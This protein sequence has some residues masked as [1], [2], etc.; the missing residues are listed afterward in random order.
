MNISPLTKSALYLSAG[1]FIFGFIDNLTLLI[2]DQVSVGQF[3]FSRSLC[4]IFIVVVFALFSGAKIF[5][6]NWKAVFARAFFNVVAML[7]YF[8]VIPMMPIA[9]AGAGLFT[10]PI[11]VLLFSFIFF[12]ESISKVQVIAF[13]LGLL[14]VFLIFGRN[15]EGLTFYHIFPILAGVSYAI[16]VILTNRYCSKETPLT[17]LLCFLVAIGIVGF[18]I[19]IWFTVYPVDEK[20]LLE[21]PFLF[22]GW[23]EM[24]A[25]YWKMIVFVGLSGA[26]AIYLMILAYQIGS[27]TYSAIYEYTYLISAGLFGWYIWGTVP[28]FL[29]FIG[30]IAIILAGTIIAINGALGRNSG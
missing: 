30:I 15:F 27:P 5:P 16:G 11:F 18:L 20:Y 2:S 10:S 21:A 17:L 8:G 4:A 28:T 9:E 24:D 29:S 6:K 22:K 3:H 26:T 19:T 25:F 1:V 13:A 14:G 12:K 7:L 23:Q